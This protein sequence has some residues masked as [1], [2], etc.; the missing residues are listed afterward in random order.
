[1]SRWLPRR[2][3]GRLGGLVLR[4]TRAGVVRVVRQDKF[5]AGATENTVDA[6]AS[7]DGREFSRFFDVGG[8]NRVEGGP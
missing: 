8:G 6:V 4:R 1:M 2:A 5:V 7:R 3:R